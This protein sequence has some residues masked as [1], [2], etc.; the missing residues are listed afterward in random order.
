MHVT[1]NNRYLQVFRLL[2][3]TSPDVQQRLHDTPLKELDSKFV[4]YLVQVNFNSL[5]YNVLPIMIK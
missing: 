5:V 4:H 1:N 2:S 3:G